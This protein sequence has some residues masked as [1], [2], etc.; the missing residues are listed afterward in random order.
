MP[1]LVKSFYSSTFEA[2]ARK[3]IAYPS[4]PAYTFRSISAR[5]LYRICR[6][7]AKFSL[8]HGLCITVTLTQQSMNVKGVHSK[9]TV[10][11]IHHKAIFISLM[12]FA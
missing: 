2:S 5:L 6:F 11:C 3:C 8:R 10:Y 9:F 4:T 1:L 12:I 7:M